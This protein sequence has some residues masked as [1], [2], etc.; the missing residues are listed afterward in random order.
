MRERKGRKKSKRMLRVVFILA[1]A[2]LFLVASM[3]SVFAKETTL[4][5]W[6]WGFWQDSLT[7][8]IEDFHKDYPEIK[9]E[10]EIMG[11]SD[12]YANLL[13][14][15]SAGEGIPDMVGLESSHLSQYVALGGLADITE[16]ISPWYDKIDQ[17]K[18]PAAEDKEGRIYAM[19]VDSGPVALYYRRDVFEQAGLAS[20]PES[21]AK[22]LDTWD[23]LYEV[24]KQIKTATGK[25]IFPQAKTNNDFRIFETLMWQQEAGYVDREGKLVI[26]SPKAVRTLEYLGKLWKEDLLLDS[27]AWTAGWYAALDAGMVATI[28]NA[29]WLGGFLWGWISPEASGKWGVVPLPVWEEDG[30]RSSNDGGSNISITKA[31][32]NKEAAWEF[33]KYIFT[34][35]EYLIDAWRAM[36][37]FPSLMACWDDPFVNEPV[38][39][40]GGQAYRKTF[41]EA[42]KVIPWWDYTKDYHEM[43]S[44]LQVY[45][46]AYALGDITSAE[47]ALAQ[48][49]AEIR[50]RTG[51]K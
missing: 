35:K 2:S 29:V 5:V 49:A 25:F 18:W 39:F 23:D 36:D 7:P 45:V 3:G 16:E 46:T 26:D 41:V 6:W 48:T 12:V 40:F 15:L 22:L 9:I 43:N 51:R 32:E 8:A 20:D 50:A 33:I 21:V 37:W 4:T 42:A 1:V 38:E 17:A 30:V 19:P 31:S 47:E 24:G 44:I 10:Q 28:P 13:L 34:N 14:A 11:P 27:P